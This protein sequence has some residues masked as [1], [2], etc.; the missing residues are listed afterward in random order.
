[1]HMLT[2]LI[3]GGDMRQDTVEVTALLREL[4]CISTTAEP[5]EGGQLSPRARRFRLRSSATRARRSNLTANAAGYRSS[6]G[7]YGAAKRYVSPLQGTMAS[8]LPGSINFQ[9]KHAD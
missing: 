1:M 9:F 5:V 2:R 8:K 6:P 7:P 3:C 4:G